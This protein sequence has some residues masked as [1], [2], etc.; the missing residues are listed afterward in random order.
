[1][2]F[3]QISL[4]TALLLSGCD[5]SNQHSGKH[6]TAGNLGASN[7]VV[8]IDPCAIVLTPLDAKEQDNNITRYQNAVR[9]NNMPL[10]N[11]EKLGWSYVEQA[12]TDLDPGYYTLA[13]KTAACIEQRQPDSP[14]AL[15]LRGHV[16]HSLHRFSE[17]EKL[18]RDLVEQRGLWLDYGLLGDA[19]ME[20]GKLDEAADA[21]QA[22]M[23]QRPGP[24]AYTR[25]A[26]LRW[27]KGDLPGAI[28]MMQMTI[29]A[30]GT[31]NAE[32][33][34]WANVRL[35]LY[36]LQAGDIDN[37]QLSIDDALSAHKDYAAALLAQG[38]LYLAQ[39]NYAGAAQVLTRAAGIDP[40]PEYRWALIEALYANHQ[41]D[42]ALVIDLQMRK[43][44]ALDD[45]RTYALY[46]A[47][48]GRDVETAVQLTT[49]ELE[50]RQDVYSLDAMAWSLHAANR[51]PEALAYS[52]RA[53]AEGTQD[54][55]LFYHAG[56]IAAASGEL[57]KAAHWLTKARSIQHMLLP[58][59]RRGLD[60]EFAALGPQTL[61]LVSGKP[62]YRDY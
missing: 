51:S 28:E 3:F 59:E 20:Q 62:E 12:R 33:A 46:L 6:K 25:A 49:R 15:L 4:L 11:L 39:H 31:R 43:T 5:Y 24:Q 22:M 36:W 17:A 47:T 37:T 14:A 21:Y 27:L 18:A 52:K 61:N 40:L 58:S 32:A 55:R 7:T 34:A 56:V 41:Y 1:M 48:T 42:Q 26:Q 16:L 30:T 29:Q 35:A 19:V 2:K 57:A 54:A 13:E 44:G 45:R 50:S 9:R 23:D 38:R 60:R 53:V 10:P 8:T